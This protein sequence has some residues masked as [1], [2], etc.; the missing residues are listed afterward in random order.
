MTSQTDDANMGHL[1]YS[2]PNV[3]AQQQTRLLI[4]DYDVCRYHSFDLLRYLMLDWEV[5]KTLHPTY[6]EMFHIYSE[7]ADQV[8]HYR[9]TCPTLNPLELFSRFENTIYKDLEEHLN[10]MFS[11]EKAK[12]VPT[13]I[14][15]RFQV[16]FDSKS[17]T[18]HLVVHEN[19][20]YEPSFYDSVDVHTVSQLFNLDNIIPIIIKHRINGVIVSSIDMAI[21]LANHLVKAGYKSPITMIIGTY[22]YNYESITIGE[23]QSGMLTMK[24]QRE[25]LI[26]E[27]ELQYEF[28][29]FDPFSGLSYRNKLLKGEPT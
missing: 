9:S 13:D 17:V 21:L 26:L 23:N 29:V 25:M 24:H 6:L 5:F 18:G 28:G 15:T 3:L 4:I 19:D 20:P 10:A 7:V 12:I 1:T 16:I 11:D 22:R 27:N 8:D 14:G 2:D